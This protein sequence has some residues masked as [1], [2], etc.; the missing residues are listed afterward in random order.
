MV[1][2]LCFSNPDFKCDYDG[3]T[4]SVKKN[5]YTHITRKGIEK[6]FSSEI[7]KFKNNKTYCRKYT[8]DGI[9]NIPII[10]RLE[11]GKLIDLDLDPGHKGNDTMQQITI[12]FFNSII[13]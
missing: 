2:V 13:N 1:S 4:C 3:K 6:K 8:S 7:Y 12:N 5:G 10:K 11:N 9:R